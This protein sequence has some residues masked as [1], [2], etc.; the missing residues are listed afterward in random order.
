S[1][2][3]SSWSEEDD[4]DNIDDSNDCDVIPIMEHNN[5]NNNNN[6]NLSIHTGISKDSDEENKSRLLK[7]QQMSNSL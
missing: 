1:I 5:N 3:V 6:N 4:T 7:Y 2:G